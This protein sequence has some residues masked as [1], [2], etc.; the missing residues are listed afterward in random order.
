MLN[1]IKSSGEILLNLINDILDS[2][3]IE[4]G[5]LNLD[6]AHFHQDK[7]IKNIRALLKNNCDENKINLNI[8]IDPTIPKILCGDKVRLNQ[9]I[10]NLVGNAIKFTSKG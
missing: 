3:K 7:C 4:S 2:S 8:N 5:K 10:M 1:I 6:N 9:I